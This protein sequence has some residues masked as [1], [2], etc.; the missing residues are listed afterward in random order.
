MAKRFTATEIWEEDW[1]LDMPNEYRLFWYYMLSKCDHAGVFKPNITR[2]NNSVGKKINKEKALM[3]FNEGKERISV[4]RKKNWWIID[5]FVFQ[6]GQIFNFNNNLH[7]S[8]YKVY[9]QEDINVRTNRG[10]KEVRGGTWTGLIEDFDT[11]KEKEIY[12]IIINK[13]INSKVKISENGNSKFGSNFKA[14]GENVMFDRLNRNLK[15][16][17]EHNREKNN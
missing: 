2:F 7:F 11:L 4:T 15:D 10:L 12:S 14:Q 13:K 16:Q 6:Y 3:F 1:F 5:F 8:I 17:T 9:N